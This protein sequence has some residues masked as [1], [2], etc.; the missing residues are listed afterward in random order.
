MPLGEVGRV[1]SMLT[2]CGQV[3][4]GAFGEVSEGVHDLVQLVAESRVRAVGMQQGRDS[5]KGN[6]YQYPSNISIFQYINIP[7]SQYSNISIFQ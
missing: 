5:V 6:I 7:I 3:S 2:R 1:E 4:G